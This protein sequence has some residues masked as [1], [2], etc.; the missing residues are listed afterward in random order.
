MTTHTAI[1]DTV[2]QLHATERAR[3][4]AL[5]LVDMAAAGALHAADFQLI[6]PIGAL[7]DR[8][9]YLGAVAAGDINYLFWEADEIDVRVMGES[10]TIRYCAELEV[11]FSGHRVART[12]YW[13]T[14][15]YERAD[16]VWQAVWSQATAI[17]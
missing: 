8:A 5:V 7:L 2:E 9:Q 13:H 3:L 4:R 1:L 14:D 12:K 15:T 10:A 16:G 17:S 6:T 11:V